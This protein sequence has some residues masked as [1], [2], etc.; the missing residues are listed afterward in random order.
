MRQ[1]PEGKTSLFQFYCNAAVL[2]LDLR[3]WMTVL[4]DFT[5]PGGL[6]I[7]LRFFDETLVL[8]NDIF[9][10]PPENL[11]ITPRRL[12][13]FCVL[14]HFNDPLRLQAHQCKP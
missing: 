10:T 12:A 14:E 6:V 3:L 2:N 11:V 9:F 7:G 13:Y 5:L 1:R 4:N 8:Q